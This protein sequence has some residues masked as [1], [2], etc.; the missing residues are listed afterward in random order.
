MNTLDSLTRDVLDRGS[1]AG[2]GDPAFN[3]A[4]Q[5]EVKSMRAAAL[6][7]KAREVGDPFSVAL[8]D[9]VVA[10]TQVSRRSFHLPRGA[11]QAPARLPR[12]V[13]WAILN[14]AA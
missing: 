2:R 1:Q 14:L 10:A 11:G 5:E 8:V 7:H 6:S 4:V 3:R 13:T 9:D 12:L